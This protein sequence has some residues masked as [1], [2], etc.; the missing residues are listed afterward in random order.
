MTSFSLMH[1]ADKNEYH[2]TCNYNCRIKYIININ[3]LQLVYSAKY[4]NGKIA[5]KIGDTSNDRYTN[6]VSDI[7]IYMNMLPKNWDTTP[8]LGMKNDNFYAYSGYLIYYNNGAE[9][10]IMRLSECISDEHF[11]M[12]TIMNG[13]RLVV[14]GLPVKHI[15]YNDISYELDNKNFDKNVAENVKIIFELSK[16]HDLISRAHEKL[17]ELSTEDLEAIIS[18]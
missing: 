7:V 14:T 3:T 13:K 1:L 5:F 4:P 17:Y 8:T 6:A 12:N 2:L 11:T 15:V 18:K 9:K 10:R 16:K